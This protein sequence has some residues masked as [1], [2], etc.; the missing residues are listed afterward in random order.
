MAY[1][2]QQRKQEIAIRIA[3]GAQ[4]GAVRNM[5]IGEGMRVAVVGVGVG[6]GASYVL[7]NLLASFLFGVK[8]RDVMVFTAVPSVLAIVALLAVSVPAVRASRVDPTEALRSS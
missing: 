3:L 2:A 7:A 8:P 5:V 1:S 6:V 4:P